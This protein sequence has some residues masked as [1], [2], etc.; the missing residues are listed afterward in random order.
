MAIILATGIATGCVY[1]LVGIG[2]SLIY[3]TTGIVNFAQGV[4][5]ALSGM[6]AYWLLSEVHLP[7]A[8]A[9]LGALLLCVA[10]GLVL[11]VLV[12]LPIWRWRSDQVSLMIALLV[13]AVLATILIQKW[14]GR[15]SPASGP[16]CSGRRSAGPCARAPPVATRAR[17]WAS[18]PPAS[19][20][21][22]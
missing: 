2:F 12:V 22:R 4:F 3:R 10:L 13:V 21:S 19:A 5:V 11:W 14:R 7:Y 20:R 16:S 8:L 18:R 1:G 17:C 9:V 15:S 6:S